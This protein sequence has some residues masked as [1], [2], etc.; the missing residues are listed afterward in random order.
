MTE[1]LAPK[2]PSMFQMFPGN[3]MWS[4]SVMRM[5]ASGAVFGEVAW[6]VRDIYAAAAVEPTGDVEAW[7]S[8]F[9]KL[10]Q[11]VE[12]VGN[13]AI[14][15]G[16][17]VTART[18]LLRAGRSR[19]IR[20]QHPERAARDRALEHGAG[21]GVQRFDFDGRYVYASPT[22]EG[23]RGNIVMI[24]DFADPSTPV[25]VGRWWMPGQWIAG[26]EQPTWPGSAHRCRHPLRFG[27]R[28]YDSYWHG[29]FVILDISDM[30]N[31]VYISGL[32]WS[33][34]FGCPTH[35]AVVVPTL[36]DGRRLLLVAD[37]DV[38]RRPD[39]PPAFLWLVDITDETQP[40]PFSSFQ[41]EGVDA[42]A[43]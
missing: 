33:P 7:Y 24:L 10:A 5:M 21:R 36:I 4:L 12:G 15:S 34:P 16:H 3:Y 40:V 9:T 35:S 17:Q 11:Q 14:A 2:R 20:R 25:E 27:D 26:G 29:G 8:A 18:A 13:D 32:Q 6:A 42:S 22:V 38:D 23:Y 43:P 30:R 39:S 1:T 41:V 31:P 19:R 28:L 37:E